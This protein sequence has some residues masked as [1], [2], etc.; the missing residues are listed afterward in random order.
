[1][2]C[3][4]LVTAGSSPQVRPGILPAHH[5]LNGLVWLPLHRL[6]SATPSPPLLPRSILESITIDNPRFVIGEPPAD[7]CVWELSAGNVVALTSCA[8]ACAHLT[9][10]ACRTQQ[11][12][13]LRLPAPVATCRAGHRRGGCAHG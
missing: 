3:T 9:T 2:D 8:C 1:M 11:T 5:P 4:P 7:C 10:L 6:L 12:V 13:C